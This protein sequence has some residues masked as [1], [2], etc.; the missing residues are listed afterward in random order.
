MC[1][2]HEKAAMA[3]SA[4]RIHCCNM[5]F[6]RELIFSPKNIVATTK[7]LENP[8]LAATSVDMHAGP[9]PLCNPHIS[10]RACTKYSPTASYLVSR[11][12]HWLFVREI[13]GDPAHYHYVYYVVYTTTTTAPTCVH[14]TT[15]S[16]IAFHKIITISPT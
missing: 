3:T 13:C 5:N 14:P 4:R 11:Q 12:M 16:S 15:T 6:T 1:G 2:H 10:R 9:G 7:C 8:L